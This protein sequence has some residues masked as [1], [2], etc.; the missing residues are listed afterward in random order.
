MA[1][2]MA[3]AAAGTISRAR[4]S[5]A[6]SNRKAVFKPAKENPSADFGRGRAADQ[7]FASSISLGE[8]HF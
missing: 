8:L 2:W 4:G 7:T 5:C 6:M 3:H 1:D